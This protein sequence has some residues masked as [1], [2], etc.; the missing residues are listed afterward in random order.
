MLYKAVLYTAVIYQNLSNT[1]TDQIRL[2]K[3]STNLLNIC[4]HKQSIP[5][6]SW[7]SAVASVT[8]SLHHDLEKCGISH[9]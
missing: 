3:P 1:D 7:A 4:G 9:C 6:L 2:V 5:A 8:T